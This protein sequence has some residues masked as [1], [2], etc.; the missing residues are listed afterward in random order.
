MP[1]ELGEL[2]KTISEISDAHLTAVRGA[3]HTA[4]RGGIHTLLLL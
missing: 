1:A 2:R 3:I 4:A